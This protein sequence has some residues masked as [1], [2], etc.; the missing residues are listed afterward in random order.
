MGARDKSRS[1]GLAPQFLLNQTP[2]YS[3]RD[4][5]VFRFCQFCLIDFCCCWGGEWGWRRNAWSPGTSEEL[6]KAVD[7]H[8]GLPKTPGPH[9][10]IQFYLTPWQARPWTQEAG[11]WLPQCFSICLF[12]QEGS[13]GCSNGPYGMKTR[14]VAPTDNGEERGPGQWRRLHWGKLPFQPNEA[15]VWG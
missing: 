15:V 7:V 12:P 4:T 11:R 1:P 13:V 5:L 14:A 8:S 3:Q 6:P 10:L 9:L 2:E